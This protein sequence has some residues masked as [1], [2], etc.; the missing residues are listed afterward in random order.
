MSY[1]QLRLMAFFIK[2]KSIALLSVLLF[3]CSCKKEQLGAVI[4]EINSPT[5]Y[6]LACVKFVGAIG[7]ACGGM[8]YR[9]S[10]LL[11]TT[12]GGAT[13]AV[14]PL[15]H[16]E[17]TRMLY[18][19]DV[20]PDGTLETAGFGGITF[21]SDDFG[22]TIF[23]RQEPRYKTWRSVC[24]RTPNNAML[25]GQEGLGEGYINAIKRQ[26]GWAYGF[27][28]V[29]HSFGMYHI[30]FVDSTVGYIAG[31]GAIYKTTNG[32]ESWNFTTAKNDYF[33][34]TSWFSKTEGVAI[35]WEGSICTTQNGGDDWQTVRS[36][37]KLGQPK[38]RLKSLAQNAR[39][40]LVAVGEKGCMLYSSDKGQ[41]W[42]VLA[43]AGDV[44]LESI[45]FLDDDTF[46]VVG[47]G[48]RIFKVQ[49]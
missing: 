22:N 13:W 14:C 30:T 18:G 27:D 3:L 49:F 20:L 12:D 9:K 29:N 15:P 36:A 45:A 48:G 40:E 16:G 2:N 46:F 19:L 33:T 44:H 35:G 6:D 5:T 11:K 23:Y 42:N 26:T 39:Q 8:D 10:E 34:A 28:D 41:H 17:D 25:C 38:I 37:N 21:H 1:L 24:F 43:E 31:F 7:F 4:T 47:Q 32:G